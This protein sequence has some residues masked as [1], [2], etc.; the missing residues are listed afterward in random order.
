M[1]HDDDTRSRLIDAAVELLDDGDSDALSLRATA[2]RAGLSHN[3]PYRHFANGEALL[4]AVA[5]RGFQRL[6]NRSLAAQQ[7]A[8]NDPLLRFRARICH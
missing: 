3:A 6:L 1:S 5:E 7:E 4:A 8:G 2:R